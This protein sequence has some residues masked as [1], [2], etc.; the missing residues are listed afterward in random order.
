MKSAAKIIDGKNMM[1]I[2][3]DFISVTG[4]LTGT[5]LQLA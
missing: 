3:N 1:Q 2:V 5:F 4:F